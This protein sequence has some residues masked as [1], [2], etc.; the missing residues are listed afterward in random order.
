MS[1][2]KSL[3]PVNVTENSPLTYTF[4]IVN[5]GNSEAGVADNIIITDTFNPPLSDITVTLNG[6][7]L[8]ATDYTY[9][10][11]TGV[12]STTGGVITVPAATYTQDPV[13]GQ[14]TSV[15]GITTLTVTGIV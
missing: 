5:T 11:A 7:P 12:F 14:W 6:A 3:N 1:I 2:T 15:P 4:T 13:T 8:P 10:E 9:S